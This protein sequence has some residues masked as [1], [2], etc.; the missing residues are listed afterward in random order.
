MELPQLT[1]PATGC[2]HRATHVDNALWLVTGPC[3]CLW[4]LTD[5]KVERVHETKGAITCLRLSTQQPHMLAL[6]STEGH[7]VLYSTSVQKAVST[8]KLCET[9]A[10]DVQFDPCSSS[11]VLVCCRNGSMSLHDATNNMAEVGRCTG[12]TADVP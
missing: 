3:L 1:G 11:Y 4:H 5:N 6:A 2:H 12:S 10:S 7:V 8:L 9:F